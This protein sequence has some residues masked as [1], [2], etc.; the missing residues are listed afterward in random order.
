MGLLV[1]AGDCVDA[2]EV[3]PGDEVGGRAVDDGSPGL[4]GELVVLLIERGMCS[5]AEVLE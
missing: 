5:S 3:V 2:G 4:L 1:L